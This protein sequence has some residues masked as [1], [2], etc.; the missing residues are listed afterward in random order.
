[1]SAEEGSANEQTPISSNIIFGGRY[2]LSNIKNT[3][4]NF[5]LAFN[6]FDLYLTNDST[7]SISKFGHTSL[8]VSTPVQISS[9]SF[10]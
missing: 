7:S 9:Q 1:M 4:L 6:F 5:D 2:Q 10:Q 8:F 3:K